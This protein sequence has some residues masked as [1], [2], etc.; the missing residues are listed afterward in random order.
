MPLA[1]PAVLDPIGRVSERWEV[2]VDELSGQCFYVD[3]YA[4]ATTWD[5]PQSW[6]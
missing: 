5:R 3:H 1:G 2:M 4:Q 6:L